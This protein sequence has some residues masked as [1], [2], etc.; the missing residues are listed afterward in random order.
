MLTYRQKERYKE[1]EDKQM[2]KNGRRRDAYR[3][4]LFKE[5]KMYIIS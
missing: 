3:K 4:I 5:R 1:K 2:K